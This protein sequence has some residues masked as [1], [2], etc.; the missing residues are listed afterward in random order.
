MFL[1]LFKKYWKDLFFIVLLVGLSF[2]AWRF[3]LDWFLQDQAFMYF[4]PVT[5]AGY[6]AS[7]LGLI[8]GSQVAGVLLSA[9]LVKIVGVNMP[10][11][12]WIQL[13]GMLS[14][15]VLFYC[16]MKVITKNYFIAFS[17]SLMYTI[18]YFGNY[19]MYIMD[20]T[21]HFLERASINVILLLL[22]LIFLHLFL[23]K[24]KRKYYL[25]AIIFYS[26]G[27]LSSHFSI[28]ITFPFFL[29]PLFWYFFNKKGIVKGFVLGLSFIL[30]SGFF[31]YLQ[32]IGI[33]PVLKNHQSFL[34]F[35]LTPQKSHYPE[36]MFRQLIYWSQYPSVIKA[37]LGGINPFAFFNPV[38]PLL[39]KQYIIIGYITAIYVIYKS[40]VNKRALLLTTIFGTASIFL[41]NLYLGR[42]DPFYT[43]GS[44]RYLYFPTF[45]LVIFWSL[46]LW[47]LLKNRN[48]VLK[49]I[50]IVILTGYYIINVRLLYLNY[51]RDLGPVV[52]Q[53]AF[54]NHIITTRNKLKPGTLVIVPFPH[55]GSYEGPF[56]TYQLGKGQVRYMSA[57]PVISEWPK[58]ASTSAHVISLKF[59]TQCQC[60][61]EEKIK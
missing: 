1:N 35:V 46:F 23:E 19:T 28:I 45:P 20:Y 39:F 37:M 33:E 59:D 44:S 56:F 27:I 32:S 17:A 40:L 49:L 29:Y 36:A 53:K 57:L 60:V 21:A 10:L 48:L 9:I 58:H 16:V 11:Y 51:I 41:F 3:L 18:S 8:S 4:D 24:G 26:L 54:F 6:T 34:Q 47:S 14:I 43:G 38:T 7:I 52:P 12:M 2:Y 61:V 25:I 55:F 13:I 15:G 22:S 5:R 31:T 42:Y 30:I 50:A